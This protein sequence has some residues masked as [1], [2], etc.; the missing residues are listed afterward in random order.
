ME[1]IQNK[2]T[3]SGARV[4]W[5]SFVILISLALLLS[6]LY[7]LPIRDSFLWY[8]SVFFCFYIPGNLLMR[9]LNSNK[10]EHFVNF[11][12]S[13]ALGTALIPLVY[14]FTRAVSRPELMYLF[15]IVILL[16]WL[17]NVRKNFKRGLIGIYSS[18]ADILSVLGLLAIILIFLH[19]SYFTDVV[20]FEKGFK[21]NTRFTETEF[22]LELINVL[23][24]VFPPHFPYASGFDFSQYHLNMHLEIEMVNRLFPIDTL[25]LTFFYFPLLYF[26]L[27]VFVPYVFISKYIQS[28]YLGILI[29]ILLFSSDLS[30]I[31]GLL[32]ILPPDFPWPLLFNPTIWSLLT[33][34]SFI[35]SLS[36]MFLCILYLKKFYENNSVRHLIVFAGLGFSAYGFKSSMGPHIM[37]AAFL[38]GIMS[39]LLMKDKKGK[40][41]C[42]ASGVSVLAMAID[43]FFLRG[44]TNNNIISLDLFN[45][46]RGSLEYLG[47]SN[48]PWF[49]YPLSYPLYLIAV[50]GMRIVGFFPLK[51]M[52][53]NRRLDSTVIFM[54]IFI[55]I[56]ITLSEIIFL[57][58]PNTKVN[59]AMWFSF[60]SLMASWLLVPYFLLRIK[61]DRVKYFIVIFLIFVLS[62]PS[63]VQFL[64][65]RFSHSYFTINSKAMGVVK[66]LETTDQKSIVLHSLEIVPSVASN[67]SGRSSVLSLIQIPV[68]IGTV[69]I[70]EAQNRSVDIGFFFNPIAGINRSPILEKY[71]VDYVL[72]LSESSKFLDKEP[73]LLQVF[74]N[75][76]FVIYKV[77]IV[78]N[79]KN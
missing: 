13:I 40:L 33:L 24:N 28:R 46:F 37:G 69:G 75:N 14:T 23:R 58:F 27:L 49:L 62:I 52:F 39:V 74:K 61:H 44:G 26:C 59:N 25:K 8:I 4:F 35:P 31:P 20:F 67:L 45:R 55:I 21:M 57:G 41:L 65:H 66:Y 70:P 50:F 56:G 1:H 78:N 19:L 32:G 43:V 73:T 22:H 63:T 2:G 12:H 79:E 77:N 18:Y 42:V 17:I 76:E 64:Y 36:V 6:Q 72:T 38:T 3:I 60:Q 7:S 11:F 29:G 10:D 68:I 51:S 5:V 53:Q 34:N 15:L 9:L 71:N 48:M 30:Y 47:L 16:I 54:L